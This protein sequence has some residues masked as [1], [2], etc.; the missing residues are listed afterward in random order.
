MSCPTI[1]PRPVRR[2]TVSF[3]LIAL[4]SSFT[5]DPCIQCEREYRVRVYD[6]AILSGHVRCRFETS[7]LY[8]NNQIYVISSIWSYLISLNAQN[9]LNLGNYLYMIR[10]SWLVVDIL[11]E[12]RC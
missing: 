4:T 6:L 1:P 5:L 11:T 12:I 9:P 7:L 2:F 8:S 10:I 3:L